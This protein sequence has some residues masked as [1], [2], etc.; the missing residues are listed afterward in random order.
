MSG[1]KSSEV[2]GLL[3]RGILARKS[4]DENFK[5]KMGLNK[6][7]LRA[8]QQE[9]DAIYDRINSQTINITPESKQE[10]PKESRHIQEQFD[11][12]KRENVKVDYTKEINEADREEKEIDS[13]LK[14][15]D[16]EHENIRRAIQRKS[17]YCD[18]EYRRAN[19]LVQLYQTI[20]EKKNKLLSKDTN[21]AQQSS[22]IAIKYRKL[23]KQ[24][25]Q[26][27]T[28]ARE[29]N[30][31][32][33]QITQLR[34][35]ATDSKKYIQKEYDSIDADL[36]MKFLPEKRQSLENEVKQFMQMDDEQVVGQVTAFAEKVSVFS[37][38]LDE[39]YSEYLARVDEVETMIDANRES[40]NSEKNFYHEP[41]DYFKNKDNAKKIDLL[42][43]LTEY[44]DKKELVEQIK[45]GIKNAQELLD[46]EKFD[47]AESQAQKNDELISQANQY[48]AL[49]QEHM[50]E[51]F[52]VAKD[53]TKVM[54]EMGFETGAYKIDGQIQ[55]G[56]RISASNPNGETIDFNK[57]FIDDAGKV[58]IEIN[59]KT[60]GDCPSKW[61]E[62]CKNFED[63]GIFIEKLT[64]ENGV[65]VY[66]KREKLVHA[67][68]DVSPDEGVRMR[69]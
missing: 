67:D 34:A 26:I 69:Q 46:A 47:E 44:S 8:N 7:I 54:K 65:D 19:E 40:L 35:K 36:A 30:E 27:A 6:K 58:S 3:S 56:W 12:I 29:L 25:E 9:L 22:Q 49:L 2:N 55:N 14:Q 50:I 4:C 13:E 53:I 17:D 18:P 48:A 31:R 43:Y 24:M 33:Q 39:K 15:A 66:N 51:N 41:V 60:M 57:V 42:A 10:F 23:E 61:D 45:A 63:M 68:Q 20:A 37:A 5:N 62:I 16:N 28:A 21:K 1:R 38:E 52:Y 59:H 32:A 64:M 11:R